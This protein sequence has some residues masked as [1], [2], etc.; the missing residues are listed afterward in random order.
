MRAR[1]LQTVTRALGADALGVDPD[2]GM[3]VIDRL[4]DTA[5]PIL[6]LAAADESYGTALADDAP[7]TEVRQP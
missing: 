7:G 1:A 6:F 5:P 4:I 3:F 2:R